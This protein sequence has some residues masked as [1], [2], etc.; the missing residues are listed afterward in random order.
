MN[1]KNKLEYK[2]NNIKFKVDNYPNSTHNVIAGPYNSHQKAKKISSY[3]E[4]KGI[5]NYV[6]S[7]RK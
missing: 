5:S 1:Y 4:N 7:Y 2:I 6:R 3:L